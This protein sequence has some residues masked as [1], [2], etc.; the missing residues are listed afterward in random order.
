MKATSSA[1]ESR[2]SSV[3]TM[4]PSKSGRENDGNRVPSGS[5]VDGVKATTSSNF[6]F[7]NFLWGFRVE[8]GE[9]AK[10]EFELDQDSHS[11]R[12]A[13]AHARPKAPL[14]GSSLG[15]LVEA[16]ALVQGAHDADVRDRTVRHH[17]GR[18]DDQSLDFRAHRFRGVLRIGAEDWHWRGNTIANVK[19][20]ASRPAT[21]AGAKAGTGPR[22]D[23]AARAAPARVTRRIAG[24]NGADRR[25]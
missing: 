6:Q 1:G 22:P 7:P 9:S 10:V 24:R 11:D 14:G 12:L 4:R 23:P 8:I 21:A 16:K 2:K 19:D 17:D 20:T 25:G 15:F 13:L 3:D 5:I 18:H